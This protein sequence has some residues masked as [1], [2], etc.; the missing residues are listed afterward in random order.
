MYENFADIYD[1]L[2][3]V[4]EAQKAFFISL[5]ENMSSPKNL[6]DVGCGTGELAITLDSYF[7]YIAAIDLDYSMIAKAVPKKHSHHLDF[8]QMNMRSIASVYFDGSFSAISCLGNTLVHLQSS[9]DIQ[10][11]INSCHQLL[12]KNGKLILQIMNYDKILHQNITTLD[13]IENQLYL[14][15]RQYQ[16]INT[17]KIIFRTIVTSKK[18]KEQKISETNLYPLISKDLISLLKDSGFEN[19]KLYDAFTKNPFTIDSA[20]LII[21]ANSISKS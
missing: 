9:L 4:S 3:P 13:N 21:E 10:L 7:N 11:F 19:L 16:I 12:R 5:A 20:V 8:K 6:L 17:E 15:E 18:T 2:F 14:F 1:E